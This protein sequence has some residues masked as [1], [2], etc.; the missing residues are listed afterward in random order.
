MD[1]FWIYVKEPKGAVCWHFLIFFFFVILLCQFWFH[2]FCDFCML[3]VLDSLGRLS[4]LSW[5]KKVSCEFLKNVLITTQKEEK[6]CYFHCWPSLLDLEED[7][8]AER[9]S[10]DIFPLWQ[11][12]FSCLEA[13]RPGKYWELIYS[14]SGRRKL[15]SNASHGCVILILLTVKAPDIVAQFYFLKLFSLQEGLFTQC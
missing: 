5:S 4:V 13:F 11:P 1:C 12:H 8:C 2:S 10:L 15:S 6:T 7:V 9:G 14:P 3:A